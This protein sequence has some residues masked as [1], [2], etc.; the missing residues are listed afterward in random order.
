MLGKSLPVRI[1]VWS[2]LFG[3]LSV[4]VCA[5]VFGW[6]QKLQIERQVIAEGRQYAER[7]TTWTL[8]YFYQQDNLLHLQT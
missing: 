8:G 1:S 7:F 2:S 3:G 6:S 5:F 4:L